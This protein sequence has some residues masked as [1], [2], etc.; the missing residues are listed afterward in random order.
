MAEH[1]EKPKTALALAGQLWDF[2]I[3]IN[4]GGFIT[5]FS[6]F[7]SEV[8]DRLSA[9]ERTQWT[10][11][12]HKD[13]LIGHDALREKDLKQIHDRFER[14]KISAREWALVILTG[15]L[16]VAAVGAWIVDLMKR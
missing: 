6:E 16:A 7:R 9:I 4:G 15:I 2:L 13:W 14:R 11:S 5:Q 3:G 10:K 8:L 12:D 1:R